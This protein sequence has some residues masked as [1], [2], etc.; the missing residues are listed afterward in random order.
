[1]TVESIDEDRHV[2]RETVDQIFRG[3]LRVRPALV[4]PIATGYPTTF[5]DIR[6]EG[7]DAR[8][9][10]L[11]RVGVAQVDARELET[12]AQKMRVRVVETGKHQTL[13]GVDPARSR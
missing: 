7:T 12:A 6:R 10:L 11:Q 8:R 4:V 13:P 3:Q 9:K 1:M 5:R 2:C